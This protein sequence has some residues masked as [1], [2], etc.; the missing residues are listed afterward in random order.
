MDEDARSLIADHLGIP[1]GNIV[2]DATFR[3]LG[4]DSLDLISLT[5]AFEEA[6]DLH[7]PDD[8][9]EA[10]TTISDAIALLNHRLEGR[11]SEI[12]RSLARELI[13]ARG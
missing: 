6:F 13:D 9:A 3:A 11:L 4:A 7:I 10:C 1:R 2:D 8:Q 12:E 5:M